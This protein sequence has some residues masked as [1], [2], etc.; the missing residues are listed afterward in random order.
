MYFGHFSEL[1]ELLP[2]AKIFTARVKSVYLVL[3]WIGYEH[4][5]IL[6]ICLLGVINLRKCLFTIVSC[7]CLQRT[8]TSLTLHGHCTVA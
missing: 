3:A 4:G 1:C 6:F 7:S 5:E 8:Q 2:L